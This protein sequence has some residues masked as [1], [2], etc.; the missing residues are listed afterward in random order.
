[1]DKIYK[2]LLKKSQLLECCTKN[3]LVELNKLNKK[4]K[5]NL[6]ECCKKNCRDELNKL[7]ENEKI[8]KQ[9]IKSD[10]EI[11][12]ANI[13][14][15]FF[16]KSKKNKNDY[17]NKQRETVIEKII[18]DELYENIFKNTNYYKKY[19]NIKIQIIN[20]IK[21]NGIDINYEKYK[22]ISKG[23]RCYN[24]DFLVIYENKDGEILK[25]IKLEFKYGT[26]EITEI[27]QFLSVYLNNSINGSFLFKNNDYIE[28]FY[29]NLVD[30]I[31]SYPKKIQNEL[32]K[33]KP[34]R[35]EDYKKIIN[36]TS[37]KN[38][39][40]KIIYEYSKKTTNKEN[41]KKYV[42]ENIKKYLKKKTIED[43]DFNQW[44]NYLIE[45]Q[46]DKIF[47]L[48]NNGE[49]KT[50]ILNLKNFNKKNTKFTKNQII[51]DIDDYLI[52]CLLRWK[53]HKGCSGPSYQISI[54]RKN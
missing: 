6:L 43:I 38:K 50:D 42:N 14:D 23:S 28:Y 29:D 24:Y 10:N 13:I 46:K 19:K 7:I 30:F 18:N 54:K 26:T 11:N 44:N 41:F 22:F 16:K 1:M 47:V 5:I 52:K 45:K 25:E 8:Y 31:N 48:C 53:N 12:S 32:I 39:F 37:Y 51:F 49:I 27:P 35:L 36:S 17:I 2:K 4:T 33:E 40:Q 21:K 15:L 34:K 20:I 3:C 9:F